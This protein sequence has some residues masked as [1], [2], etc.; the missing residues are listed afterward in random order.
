MPIT[1]NSPNAG[2]EGHRSR[3]DMLPLREIILRLA[4]NHVSSI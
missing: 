1:A 4:K 2:D 3:A